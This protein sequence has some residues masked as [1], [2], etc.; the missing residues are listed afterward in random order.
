MARHILVTGG[1]GFI[2]SHLIDKLL[3]MGDSVSVLD[4]FNDYY[5]PERK[6]LN[7]QEHLKHPKYRIVEGDLRNDAS[8]DEVFSHGQF[9]GIVHLAAMAG[10]RP[11]LDQAAY[12]MDVNLNGTQ[13]LLDRI[14]KHCPKARLAFGSS[15]SV[16]GGRSGESFKET[17]RIDQPFSPYAASKAAGELICYSAHHTNKLQ[18]VCL[19]F[20]TVFGPRQRPDLAIHKFC[21]LIS[22]GQ[23]IEVY[24]DG[25]TK[26]D[27]T[28]VGDIVDG[29]TSALEYDL[30]GYD[31]IN[32]GR[33]EPVVLNDMIKCL[34]KHIGKKAEIIHMPMQTGDVP[35][36]YASIDKARRVLGYE[37]KVTFDEGVKRFVEWHKSLAP[38]A[39]AVEV[40]A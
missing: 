18:V 39:Q 22:N 29:I 31:I 10:V 1:A 16:Y 36:T 2:G 6:R 13:K 12:Y 5:N 9:D 33:S 7:I 30:P 25:S 17:D 40:R 35:F 8:L 19:R 24:G 32:L 26:R 11:S 34:E 15:S 21:K 28:Y 37:P 23:P 27:Y 4:N 38:A 14:A 20:F 3:S